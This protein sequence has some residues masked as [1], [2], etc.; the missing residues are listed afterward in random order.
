[1]FWWEVSRVRKGESGRKE[2]E[3]D[4]KGQLLTNWCCAKEIGRVC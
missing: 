2:T 1:M 3:K 4:E